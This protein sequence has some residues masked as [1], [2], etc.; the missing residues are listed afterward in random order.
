MSHPRQRRAAAI[1]DNFLVRHPNRCDHESGTFSQTFVVYRRRS[2]FELRKVLDMI[3]TN[4]YADRAIGFV[5]RTYLFQ[6]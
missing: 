3:G 1:I 6:A 4:P 5:P 2:V